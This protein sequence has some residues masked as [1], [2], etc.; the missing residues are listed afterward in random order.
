ML[1]APQPRLDYKNWPAPSVVVIADS[2]TT[3]TERRVRQ[4]WDW[5]G[6]RI[7]PA[8]GEVEDL[9]ILIEDVD[10]TGAS[11]E[12]LKVGGFNARHPARGGD[13]KATWRPGDPEPQ[14]MGALQAAK[15]IHEFTAGAHLLGVCPSF[16]EETVDRTLFER[17]DARP[18]YHYH[19]TCITNLACGWLANEVLRSWDRTRAGRLQRMITPPYS[20]R[21]ISAALGIKPA[22]YAEHT[23]WGDV[24][25]ATDMHRL[26]FPWMHNDAMTA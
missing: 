3:H 21:D 7:D 1:A 25:W 13:P 20:S 16:D 5:A 8:T 23:A 2:E 14:V 26:M 18:A 9:S 15:A 19:L 22:G 10:L 4:I 12:A 11:E 24:A 6:R 17:I